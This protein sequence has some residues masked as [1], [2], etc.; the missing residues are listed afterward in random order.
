MYQYD[1]L[2]VNYLLTGSPEVH[3][4]LPV[5]EQYVNLSEFLAKTG[6]TCE[7]FAARLGVGAPYVSMLARGLRTPS[8]PLAMRIASEASIPIE[9]LLPT[10][11]TETQS[12]EEGA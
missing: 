7:S 4:I 3:T 12:A 2:P 11:G 9:S 1:T 8:L 5:N 10:P 6:T